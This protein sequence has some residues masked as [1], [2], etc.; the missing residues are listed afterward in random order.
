M[1]I[2]S[3]RTHGYRTAFCLKADH[4]RAYGNFET[5]FAPNTLSL[6]SQPTLRINPCM[7][8]VVFSKELCKGH[9]PMYLYG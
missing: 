5:G 1:W 9:A 8:L 3:R 6:K 7:H 2:S 4:V